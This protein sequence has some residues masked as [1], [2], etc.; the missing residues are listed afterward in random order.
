MS[1]KPT[2]YDEGVMLDQSTT[3]TPSECECVNWCRDG[4][5]VPEEILAGHHFRCPKH[6]AEFRRRSLELIAQLYHAM[7]EWGAQ[8]DGVPDEAWDAWLLAGV[9]TTGTYQGEEW[10]G[11][12]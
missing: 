4:L 6:D 8:E 11:D 12:A 3:A 2:I 7:R 1:E 9:V 5:H 10:R